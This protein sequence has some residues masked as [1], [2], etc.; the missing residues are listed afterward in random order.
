MNK[1]I[2]SLLLVISMLTLSFVGCAPKKETPVDKAE[3]TE[4]TTEQATETTEAA[5]ADEVTLSWAVF[6]T[7][8]YTA[9]FWQHIIDT[10]EADNPGIKIEKVLMTGDSRAQFLKTMLSAGELPDI[11]I[12]PT[13]LAKIE[14]VYA[15]VPEEL[16]AKFE[17]SAVVSFNG[18]KNLIPASKQLRS[19]AFYNKAQFKDAGITAAPKTWAEFL[20]ACEKLKAKGYTPLITAGAGDIWATGFGYWA[21]VV[22]SEVYSAYPN[23]NQ[24]VLSGKLS[25]TDPVIVDALQV[26]Q[27]LNTNGNF[28][29]GS[30]SYSYGQASSEFFSGSA[31]MMLDGSWVAPGIDASTEYSN[32]DFGSFVMPTPTGAKTYCSANQYWAVAETCEN[33][34]AAFK[35]CEYVLGGNPELYQYY[36]KTDGLFAATKETVT[37]EMGPAQTEFVDNYKGYQ[38]VPEI[39]KVLGDVALPTGFEDFVM[40]SLQN[41]FI[42]ADVKT[43]LATWDVEMARL[44]EQ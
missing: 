37:Y 43:E 13:E 44:M 35:F 10:F 14:G 8:N 30:M 2:L 24:D 33:K 32:E 15:A 38:S 4:A 25:W 34:E 16:L 19:Q 5:S 22:N 9:E 6:E 29:K 28:N 1:K 17:D 40:K 31:A 3:V 18:V 23:F 27:D 7:D 36:L 41:V 21:G 20:D 39:T 12:D 42:G 26:W 11:N